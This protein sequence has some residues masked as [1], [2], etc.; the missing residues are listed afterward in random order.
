MQG[1]LEVAG[2]RVVTA[3]VVRSGWILLDLVVYSLNGAV[4]TGSPEMG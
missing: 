4:V 3:E 2:T 1:N